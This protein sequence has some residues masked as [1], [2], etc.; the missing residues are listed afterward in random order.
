MG[1]EAKNKVMDFNTLFEAV[2][3]RSN[4]GI[5]QAVVKFINEHSGANN[6][7]I[8]SKAMQTDKLEALKAINC[9]LLLIEKYFNYS[10]KAAIINECKLDKNKVKA[11]KFDTHNI[12]AMLISR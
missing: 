9:K 10:Y 11:I 12:D 2:Q 8:A 5:K 3:V 6:I 1:N 4:N 7:I